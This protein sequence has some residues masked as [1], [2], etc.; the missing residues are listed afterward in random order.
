MDRYN[1]EQVKGFINAITS[2]GGDSYPKFAEFYNDSN[3]EE[4]YKWLLEQQKVSDVTLYRGYTFD[5]RYLED[6]LMYVGD[7]G[8]VGVD[9]LTQEDCP[10]FTTNYLRATRYIQDYGCFLSD[11]QKVMFEIKTRGKWFV[12]ISALSCYPEEHEHK[13]HPDVRLMVTNIKHGSLMKINLEEI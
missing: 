1:L 5:R 3:K 10:S 11:S 6:G 13:C 12:D 9:F 4:Y 2:Y 8:I 7:D